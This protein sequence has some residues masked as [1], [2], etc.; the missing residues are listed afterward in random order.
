V[1]IADR[2]R[3]FLL[4][5]LIET[6]FAG[7]DEKMR[8]FLMTFGVL[9]TFPS[10]LLALDLPADV[11]GKLPQDVAGAIGAEKDFADSAVAGGKT[12]YYRWATSGKY[13][14]DV[15]TTV[16]LAGPGLFKE[17][18]VTQVEDG[19]ATTEIRFSALGGLLPLIRE[20]AEAGKEAVGEALAEYDIKGRLFPLKPGN[21]FTIAW[22]S[23]FLGT[24]E[25]FMKSEY[26][27]EV[28]KVLEAAT[29]MPGL[30]GQAAE[31]ECDVELMGKNVGKEVY[32][33][34]AEIGYFVA[35]SSRGARTTQFDVKYL[36]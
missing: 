27:C 2:L 8:Q 10:T 35:D 4:A 32:Y 34:L 5:R 26:D 17:E 6:D 29:F 15:A 23:V 18:I 14:S 30:S 33:Y 36:P 22:Q 3:L 9:L 25:P 31:V 28:T 7:R 21:V 20:D 19:K 1:A 12:L 11:A 16:T 13:A 24:D